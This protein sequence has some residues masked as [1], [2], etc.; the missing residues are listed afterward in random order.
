MDSLGFGVPPPPL[1]ACT[2]TVIFK[3]LGPVTLSCCVIVLSCSMIWEVL[4]LV[5]AW[6]LLNFLCWRNSQDLSAL[7]PFLVL[8]WFLI[9]HCMVHM[10]RCPLSYYP[11]LMLFSSMYLSLLFQENIS[12]LSFLFSHFLH[13]WTV[14][15]FASS[16]MPSRI[17]VTFSLD[18]FQ[19]CFVALLYVLHLIIQCIITWI[20]KVH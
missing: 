6:I 17:I 8:L 19:W 13:A 15:L 18:F 2:P 5:S 4:S 3:T 1:K 7:F 14:C 11:Y 9:S 20:Y 12:F 10:W 16:R